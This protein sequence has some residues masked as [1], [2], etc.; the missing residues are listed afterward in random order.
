MYDAI[1]QN[2]DFEINL[3]IDSLRLRLGI[4]GQR[5]EEALNSFFNEIV[6]MLLPFHM[7]YLIQT[8]SEGTEVFN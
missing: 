6:N 4:S 7:K 2:D 8:A 1:K 3:I 5:R